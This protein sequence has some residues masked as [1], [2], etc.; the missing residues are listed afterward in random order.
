MN[1]NQGG[2][3]ILVTT[4]H[5]RGTP[6]ERREM[7]DDLRRIVADQID[8]PT[9]LASRS[10]TIIEQAD[11]GHASLVNLSEGTMITSVYNNSC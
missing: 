4:A 8:N 11:A 6:G 3:T 9:W 5:G 10:S 7:W 1:Y 2:L